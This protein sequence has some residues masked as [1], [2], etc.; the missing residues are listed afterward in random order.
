M[1]AVVSLRLLYSIFQRIR[2][3][4]GGSGARRYGRS[5]RAR[6]AD[7]RII[8][9]VPVIGR[10]TCF[11]QVTVPATSTRTP[12][13]GEPV[14]GWHPF[15]ALGAVNEGP[16]RRTRF[17]PPPHPHPYPS[18]IGVVT[19]ESTVAATTGARIAGDALSRG[20]HPR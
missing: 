17:P 3:D 13:Q 14:R 5:S 10:V 18:G 4:T 11:G 6:Q 8:A 15:R 19:V 2:A 20:G 16:F 7:P 1:I 9:R 12:V